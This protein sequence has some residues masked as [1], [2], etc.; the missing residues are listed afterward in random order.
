MSLPRPCNPLEGSPAE[1]IEAHQ[2][3]TPEVNRNPANEMSRVLGTAPVHLAADPSG[4]AI[5]H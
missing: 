5:A 2:H 1:T 3:E 4:G